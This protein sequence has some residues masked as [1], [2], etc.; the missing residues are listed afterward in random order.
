MAGDQSAAKV[1]RPH[2]HRAIALVDTEKLAD[3]FIEIAHVIAVALLAEAA[4]AVKILTDLRDGHPHQKRE[5]CRGDAQLVF[6]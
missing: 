3:L 4:E 1:A 2:D 6:P 5:T